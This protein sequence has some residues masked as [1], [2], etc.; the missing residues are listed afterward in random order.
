MTSAAALMLR[1]CPRC[2]SYLKALRVPVLPQGAQPQTLQRPMY[3]GSS[4]I[5]LKSDDLTAKKP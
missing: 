4:H 2:T 3:I 1:L 5:R